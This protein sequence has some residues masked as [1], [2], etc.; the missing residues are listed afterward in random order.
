MED[1]FN[2]MGGEVVMSSSNNMSEIS[3]DANGLVI[4]DSG[5]RSEQKI[6]LIFS[7]FSLN[8]T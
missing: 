3:D 4:D 2:M 7:T 6:L 8:I 1:P 5:T